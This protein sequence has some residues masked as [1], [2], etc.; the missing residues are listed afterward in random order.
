M[1]SP[2]SR[3]NAKFCPIHKGKCVQTCEFKS[4]D[5]EHCLVSRL[6]KSLDLSAQCIVHLTQDRCPDWDGPYYLG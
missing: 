3:P 2:M 5:G 4:E 1:R 6:L